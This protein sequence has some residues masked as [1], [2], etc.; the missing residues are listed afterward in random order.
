MIRRKEEPKPEV[1]DAFTPF[2]GLSNLPWSLW[3]PNLAC[4]SL[5]VF[6][7]TPNFV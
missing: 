2:I 5:C 4:V 7:M 6:E 3:E 1:D